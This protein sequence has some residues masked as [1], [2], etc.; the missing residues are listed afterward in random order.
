MFKGKLKNNLKILQILNDL[1]FHEEVLKK[2]NISDLRIRS[3]KR[4]LEEIYVKQHFNDNCVGLI[5]F[6]TKINNPNYFYYKE[7]KK[8]SYIM[9]D[10]FGFMKGVISKIKTIKNDDDFR[11]NI[12]KIS[13]RLLYLF[14]VN[15]NFLASDKDNKIEMEQYPKYLN[16]LL[17]IRS[18]IMSF[19][20]YLHEEYKVK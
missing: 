16:S 5:N 1:K 11:T 6:L 18:R 12:V 15:L 7:Y 17:E 4:T 2:W 10:V 19:L 13:R 20:R 8:V 14:L 9:I 3:I